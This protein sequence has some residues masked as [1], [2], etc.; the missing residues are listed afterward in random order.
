MTTTASAPRTTDGDEV[1]TRLLDAAEELFAARGYDGASTREIGARAGIGKRMLFYYFASKRAVY[2]AV[3]ERVITG[4]VAIHEK[5][6]NDPGPVGLAEAI[7]GITYFAA[8]N[9]RALTVLVREIMD[10]GPHVR[11]LAASHL[12]PLFERSGAELR[13]NMDEGVF[14]RED[15]MHV[16]LSVGGIT[17]YYFLMVPL[18]QRIW[19]RDPLAPET[20]AQ[21]AAAVRNVLLHGLTG[22]SAQGGASP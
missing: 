16:L 15:P 8:A 14:R 13:R 5:F 4:M 7:E 12:G 19:D 20:L 1:R 9:I 11:D 3:L 6:R 22:A 10:D 21:R 18:L 2:R 17:M